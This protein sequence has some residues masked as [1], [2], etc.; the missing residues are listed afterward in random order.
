MAKIIIDGEDAILA[1]EN[2]LKNIGNEEMPIDSDED[3]K[4]RLIIS[5]Q[6]NIKIITNLM[7]AASYLKLKNRKLVLDTQSKEFSLI[8]HLLPK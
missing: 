8:S 5:Y 7:H 2:A 4:F 3:F 1:C 6:E